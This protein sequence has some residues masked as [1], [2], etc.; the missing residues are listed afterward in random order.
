L[1]QSGY[2]VFLEVGP[3][4]TLLGIAQETIESEGRLWLPTIRRSRDEWQQLLETAAALHVRGVEVDWAAADRPY[5]RGKVA[6]PTYPFERERCWTDTSTRKEGPRPASPWDAALGA[7][8][9]QAGQAPLDLS[10]RAFP[11]AW[12][13]FDRLATAYQLTALA[14][15]GA[16]AH[17]G[18]ESTPEELC[19]RIGIGQSHVPLLR[20][21]LSH[22]AEEGYL[23]AEGARY[24]APR[25]LPAGN[26]GDARADADLSAY[27]EMLAYVDSCGPRL[28]AVLTG[29]ESPLE[30]LFP[31]GSLALTTGLYETSAVSRY[32]NA[33]VRTVV[34]SATRAAEGEVRVLEVGAGTGGTTS[35]VLPVL[36]ADR[37]LYFF[38]DVSDA[39]LSQAQ[40]RFNAYAFL[41]YGRLDL[42]QDPAAQGFAA[43]GFDVILAANVLHATRDLRRTLE[44]VR[45]LAAPGALLVLS[46]TTT[47]HRVFDVTTGLIEG[48]EAFADDIR[49]DDPLVSTQQ[50]LRLLAEA[51]FEHQAALPEP[52]GLADVLGNRVIVAAAPRTGTRAS[53]VEQEETTGGSPVSRSERGGSSA[54]VGL[55]GA[56]SEALPSERTDVLAAHARVRVMEILRLD[57]AHAPG[58]DDRLM[59]LGFDSLMA[60]QLRSRLASDLGLTTR[61]PATIVFD[62][63]TCRALGAFLAG[64]VDGG[65]PPATPET[66]PAVPEGKR[67]DID[68]LSE[69]QVEALLLE[70]LDS[71]E[72]NR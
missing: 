21:W 41:R 45:S 52:G 17:S 1:A 4:S 3:G 70:R 40:E 28:A 22:L 36:P 25:P 46:E 23:R 49:G 32:L 69:E 66:P 63:P 18:E 8:R 6:L 50:W 62:H 15:L 56:L 42:E 30:T 26:I 47:H 10:L 24:V 67:S 65:R 37:T 34:E 35:A 7:G 27:P 55:L 5:A 16:F 31:D 11:A 2:R 48:W 61:L 59:Q 19:G 58:L 20:R 60:M 54:E 44:R 38:T 72:G 57:A 53:T 14:E 12:K 13:A 64:Q 33:I 71:I 43:G 68:G 9:A 29:R 39:F 51:G